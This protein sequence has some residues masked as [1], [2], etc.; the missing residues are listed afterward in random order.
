M[1]LKIEIIPRDNID[2]NI[3]KAITELNDSKYVIRYDI[4]NA[5]FFSD[6][7]IMWVNRD[8]MVRSF[9]FTDYQF[10]KMIITIDNTMED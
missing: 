7:N 9:I 5:D 10:K 8:N 3:L 1:F 6:Y 2:K 4:Y